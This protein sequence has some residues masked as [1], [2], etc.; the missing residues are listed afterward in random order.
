MI[1]EQMSYR[2]RQEVNKKVVDAV[3][4]QIEFVTSPS[5]VTVINDNTIKIVKNGIMS[6]V[7]VR[8]DKK[9]HGHVITHNGRGSHYEDVY[10][11]K[12]G[13]VFSGVVN[14]DHAKMNKIASVNTDWDNGNISEGIAYNMNY[15]EGKIKA[16]PSIRYVRPYT[17][18]GIGVSVDIDIPNNDEWEKKKKANSTKYAIPSG[19]VVMKIISET[20]EVDFQTSNR[21]EIN[22]SGSVENMMK[23]IDRITGNPLTDW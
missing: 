1:T 6:S 17:K 9:E 18:N 10:C 12:I 21:N 19:K 3:A 11:K 13:T 7:R 14:I 5:K 4:K 8:E 2:Q 20:P 23:V 15:D 22:I 16:H